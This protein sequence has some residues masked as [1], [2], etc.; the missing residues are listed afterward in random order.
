M[1]LE[2][3]TDENKDIFQRLDNQKTHYSIKGFYDDRKRHEK[4]IKSISK[5]PHS[6]HYLPEPK[7]KQN[8][9]VNF[10]FNTIHNKILI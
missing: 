10:A 6:F 2:K 5:Y 4:I 9:H 7:E 1:I 8:D 3:I